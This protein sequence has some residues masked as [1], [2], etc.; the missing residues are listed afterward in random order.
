MQFTHKLTGNDT[1]KTAKITKKMIT[2]QHI[3]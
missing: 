1:F 2:H 3:A